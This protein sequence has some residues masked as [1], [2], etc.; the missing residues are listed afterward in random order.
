MMTH[1]SF[2]VEKLIIHYKFKELGVRMIIHVT[3]ARRRC[4]TYHCPSLSGIFTSGT[5][6][7][8]G[9]WYR[10]C[11]CDYQLLIARHTMADPECHSSTVLL[12]LLI[13]SMLHTTPFT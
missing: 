2:N 8:C 6:C 11:S 13:G 9:C 7:L 12:W 3:F 1:I 10:L 4:S 5:T